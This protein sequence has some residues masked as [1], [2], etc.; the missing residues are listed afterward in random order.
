MLEENYF[1]L[2]HSFLVLIFRRAP[3]TEME[4]LHCVS[5]IFFHFWEE[6]NVT[7]FKKS[8]NS[9]NLCN[10]SLPV[11]SVCNSIFHCFSQVILRY[12]TSVKTMEANDS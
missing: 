6:K 5:F 12:L 7:D 10:Y 1:C 8:R 2:N 9:W 11:P 3:G 4:V